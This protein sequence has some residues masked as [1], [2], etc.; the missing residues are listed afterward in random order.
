MMSDLARYIAGIAVRLSDCHGLSDDRD[1]DDH[2]DEN[3]C[4][5]NT[6]AGHLDLLRVTWYSLFEI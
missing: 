4:C 6:N 5:S 3:S 2:D 1:C